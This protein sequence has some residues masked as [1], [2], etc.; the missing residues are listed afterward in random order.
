MLSSNYWGLSAMSH[1]YRNEKKLQ[2]VKTLDL[3]VIGDAED[4]S[5]VSLLISFRNIFC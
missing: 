1:P 2:Q 3:L 5:A 4:I